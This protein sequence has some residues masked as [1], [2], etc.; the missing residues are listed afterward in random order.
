MSDDL[1]LDNQLCFAVHSTAHA[2]ARAYRPL[3]DPLGL[4]YPQY[5]TLL[6]LWEQD[7][8]TV[9]D[10]GA[11]LLIDSGTLTPLL[12][13]LEAAGYV[14][15]RRSDKDERQVRVALTA[16]GQALKAKAVCIP[17]EMGKAM[18]CSLEEIGELRERLNELR[19]RLGQVT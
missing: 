4:T 1:K 15:R 6:V 14:T 19:A 17:Q 5:L 16:A 11:R 2:I 10:I 8:L 9:S 3:L 12:K 7:D 18:G 13:R